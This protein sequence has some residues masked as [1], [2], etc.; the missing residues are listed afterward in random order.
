[1]PRAL[2]LALIGEFNSE[3][4]AHQAIPTA[5]KL[6]ADNIGTS[7]EAHWTPTDGIRTESDVAGFD[8]FWCVPAG[9]HRSVDGAS[10]AIRYARLNARPF[11]GTCAGFQHL[12]LEYAQS[13]LGWSDAEHGELA[14]QSS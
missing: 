1:M 11:L 9:P 7:I 3:A 6:A 10:L 8:G 5:L 13:V 12:I 14:P 2:Q 4:L